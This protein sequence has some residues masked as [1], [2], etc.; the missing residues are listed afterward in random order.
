M[1]TIPAWKDGVGRGDTLNQSF[2]FFS[3]SFQVCTLLSFLRLVGNGG[4]LCGRCEAMTQSCGYRMARRAMRLP[5]KPPTI[6]EKPAGLFDNEQQY[7][8]LRA[9]ETLI[10]QATRKLNLKLVSLRNHYTRNCL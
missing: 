9:S 1:Q 10:S 2:R 3:I 6:I 5:T 8:L 4:R 7:K